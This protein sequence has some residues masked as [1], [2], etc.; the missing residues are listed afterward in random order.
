MT[1]TETNTMLAMLARCPH[2][3]RK[4]PS[5]VM[6]G[7]RLKSFPS[8]P[9]RLGRHMGFAKS[10]AKFY[11]PF[12]SPP[13]HYQNQESSDEF[14][15]NSRKAYSM[16]R[17]SRNGVRYLGE[18][19]GNIAVNLSKKIREIR[20]VW[21]SL[22]RYPGLEAIERRGVIDGNGNCGL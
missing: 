15:A 12:P 7:A 9:P 3:F 14:T 18:V 8:W 22:H 13:T 4:L 16:T 1:I 19:P 11:L 6:R 21:T 5:S 17:F 10:D 20:I 2:T